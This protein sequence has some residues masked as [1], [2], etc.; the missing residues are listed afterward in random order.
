MTPPDSDRR[1]LSPIAFA[2]VGSE[3]ASFTLV[4]V[5]I[6]YFAG[7]MPWMTVGLTLLGTVAAMVHLIRMALPKN[8][9]GGA[10]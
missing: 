4:G 10:S 7:T 6:D 5:G 3:M 1:P 8:P 9:P 2:V